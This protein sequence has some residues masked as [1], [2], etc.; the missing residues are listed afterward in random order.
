MKNLFRT[1]RVA[2]LAL[3]CSIASPISGQI[4]PPDYSAY[5]L[6]PP[7]PETPRI[8]SAKVFGVRPGSPFLYN[9]AATGKR[10]ITFSAEGLPKGLKLDP[11]TG[12]IR[13]KIKKRG[14]YHVVLHA[15]NSMGENSRNLRIEVGDEIALTPPMGWNSWNCWGNSVSQEKVMSSAQAMVDKG[16]AD[17]GWTYINI[18]DGWQGIR[19]GRHNAVQTNRK[20]PDMKQLADREKSEMR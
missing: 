1:V 6:T 3:S 15:R 16:L 8:N 20:F 17:Y 9:I 13:G 19:G 11:A 18:D 4:T 2:A 10:P 14:T 12:Y 5:I 7:A